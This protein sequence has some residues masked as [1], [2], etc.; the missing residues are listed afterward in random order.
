[1]L[2]TLLVQAHNLSQIAGWGY[3][4]AVTLLNLRDTGA[5]TQYWSV[6]GYRSQLEL[7]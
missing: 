4:L 5:F 2:K 6:P 3:L 7:F 1:M